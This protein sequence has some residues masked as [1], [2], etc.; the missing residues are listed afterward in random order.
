MSAARILERDSRL[1]EAALVWQ[2][3]ADEYPDNTQTSQ[4]L[5]LAGIVQYRRG[6]YYKALPIFQR[7]LLL[8]TEKAEQARAYLW[9]GKTQG[10]LGDET[11]KQTAWQQAQSIDPTGYYSERSP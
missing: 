7:S 1:E 5:F 6:D 8:S 3:V 4:A 11:A 9:I 10:Q 2:R